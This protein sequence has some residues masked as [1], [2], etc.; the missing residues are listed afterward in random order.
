M[1]ALYFA[2]IIFCGFLHDV[3]SL[4]FNFGDFELFHCYNALPKCSRCI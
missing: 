2:G 1:K 3:S 4:E